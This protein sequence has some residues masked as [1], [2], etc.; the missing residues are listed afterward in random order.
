M[1][2]RFYTHF[3]DEER[4]AI[5]PLKHWHVVLAQTYR[6]AAVKSI[7]KRLPWNGVLYCHIHAIDDPKYRN[8]MPITCQTLKLKILQEVTP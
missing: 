2:R 4:A 3:A 8:G 6:E 5:P 7:S 1:R